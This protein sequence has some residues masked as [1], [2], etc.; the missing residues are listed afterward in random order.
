[1]TTGDV[2]R[3]LDDRYERRR[4]KARVR[5]KEWN[6]LNMTP[7][8]HSWR[9]MKERCL[10]ATHPAYEHYGGRG[11][12]ICARWLG[13]GGFANFLVDMGERPDGLTLDRIDNDGNY[14]PGN[15]RWATSSEQ[16]QNKR[17]AT[18][19]KRGHEFS[20]GNTYYRANGRRLCRACRDA[21]RRRR[22]L[23]GRG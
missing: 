8:R 16:A 9:A 15:C 2:V 10:C 20:E 3:V 21:W 12:S 23:D 6:R 4:A 1:M 7:T 17:Q 13:Q 19:C 22:Y 11:I 14:E 5:V 18:H